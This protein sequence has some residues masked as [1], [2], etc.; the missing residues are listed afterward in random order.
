MS[1]FEQGCIARRSGKLSDALT[2]FEQALTC[3]PPY[4]QARLLYAHTLR[5][6]GEDEKAESSYQIFLL[7]Q[8]NSAAALLGLAQC[9]RNR[10]GSHAALSHFEAALKAG[11]RESRARLAYA[12]ILKDLKLLSEAETVHRALTV[13]EP[14]IFQAHLGLGRCIRER[15][16][17]L[18]AL[19]Y[20]KAAV[21][22]A[23]HNHRACLPYADLLRELNLIVQ[24]EAVYRTLV[25]DEP[26]VFQAHLGLARCIREREGP[27]AALPH[28]EAAAA[29]AP[30]NHRACLPY[31]D[32]LRELN[33]IVQAE[34]VYRA[35]VVDEPQV[36][37]A[38]LGLG[39]C[40]RER[41][42]PLS[43]LPYFKAAVDAAP[44]N[45]RAC[46][47]YADLLRELNFTTQAEAVYRALTL[48][49]PDVFQAHLGLGRCIR[50]RE[51]PLAALPHFKAAVV[52]APN[53]HRVHLPYAE[54]LR[55]LRMI[56]DAETV[57]RTLLIDAPEMFQAHL[58]LGR[59]VREREGPLAALPH[60]EAAV[61]AAPCNSVARL[62]HAEALRGLARINEA[63]AAYKALLVDEPNSVAPL[64]GLARCAHQAGDTREAL[65]HLRKISLTQASALEIA[66]LYRN[67]GLYN[68][69]RLILREG[70]GKNFEQSADAWTSLGHTESQA[71]QHLAA[72]NAF[73]QAYVVAPNK[74][75]LI[76]H[77]A[78]KEKVLGRFQA[79]EELL[80][81]ASKIGA[82]ASLA[83]VRL[84]ENA[85]STKN[86]PQALELA[87]QA[88]S[89]Q[90]EH[91]AA[92]LILAQVR[93]DS[94]FLDEAVAGLGATTQTKGHRIEF[95][96]KSSGLLRR[97]GRLQ[98]A[99]DVI[100][101]ARLRWPT[102]NRLQLERF[103][104][105]FARGSIDGALASLDQFQSENMHELA[106]LHI[107]RGAIA[108]AL[109]QHTAA[110]EHYNKALAALPDN[111]RAHNLLA[112]AHLVKGDIQASR[113][114]SKQMARLVAPSRLQ[115]GLS[116]NPSQSLVGQLLD[117]Y[118]IDK[119]AFKAL[120]ELNRMPP[121][122]R[123]DE[124]L[125][126]I[127]EKPEYT[128]ASI[129]L[130]IALRNLGLLNN[131]NKISSN[132]S[133]IPTKIC[134][135]W[136][137]PEVPEDLQSLM[138]SWSDHNPEHQYI[139]FDDT[140]AKAFLTARYPQ[141][142]VNAYLLVKEPAAKADFFRLAYLYAEGGFYCDADDRCQI[143]L[144][145]FIPA[146]AD[147]VGWH[148]VFGTLGNNFLGAIPEH[149]AIGLALMLSAAAI[150]RG[151]AD[152]VWLSSGPGLVTR[153]F[154]RV[155]ASPNADW[156]SIV[157]RTAILTRPELALGVTIHCFSSYKNTSK[158]WAQ[159][160]FDNQKTAVPVKTTET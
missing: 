140:S 66:A 76:I 123:V 25:V 94:G 18:A 62:S 24:A 111:Y 109:W 32:L 68:A 83:F 46:L 130:F 69:S 86:F 3:E 54:I 81:R 16:G 9:V 77:I 11:P 99:L 132:T 89:H 19:P 31:A 23:P 153:A 45:H 17:S 145:A 60:F 136:D 75:E 29:A 125:S 44:H 91:P 52:A 59:C 95:A 64:I 10:H 121:E 47:P 114:H 67:W 115:K 104:T 8:P 142:F 129:A 34:A 158:H 56:T 112:S 98:E 27:L 40:A 33:L 37:Q 51:G 15:E 144:S 143:P 160:A 61:A 116:S 21:D 35:L 93:A 127:R 105:E 2:H 5:E 96:L 159:S 55:E 139:R 48:D 71:G 65:D 26:Q 78:T 119:Q 147:F 107:A 38:H 41:E 152:V 36:F 4:P 14:E 146:N 141:S 28:F 30:H 126:L 20:F 137:Q 108:E 113:N 1:S 39:R 156:K 79:A 63:R 92:P 53:D 150:H 118:L 120:V 50:E 72:I 43:A 103:S 117:E 85:C 100:S 154:A 57:Y 155:L 73:R 151:D 22:A 122:N 42:G 84:A 149:P 110:I 90:P 82:I 12:D 101:E 70:F 87:L 97:V 102:S 157:E 88:C 128:P 131:I 134:Q 124:L 7:N 49:E 6:L 148:E 135:F 106:E 13:D 58:G 74:H 138:K 80:Q 133:P